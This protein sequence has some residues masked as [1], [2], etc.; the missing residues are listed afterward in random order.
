MKPET[1]ELK[2]EVKRELARYRI[3]REARE[4][5]EAALRELVE[6]WDQ[7]FWDEVEFGKLVNKARVIVE[8]K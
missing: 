8:G 7:S 3:Q 2:A 1:E 6:A 5:A 4:R